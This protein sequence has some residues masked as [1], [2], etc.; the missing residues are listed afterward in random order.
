[1]N[2]LLLG[3]MLASWIVGYRRYGLFSV[4]GALLVGLTAYSIPV[5]LQTYLVPGYWGLSLATV[6]IGAAYVVV[7]AWLWV[8]LGLF[9]FS[10]SSDVVPGQRYWELSPHQAIR[11]RQEISVF[12]VLCA[13]VSTGLYLWIA[14]LDDPLYFLQDRQTADVSAEYQKMLWRWVNVYG[15]ITAVFARFKFLALLFLS[16]IGIYFLA[17]DRTMVLISGVSLLVYFLTE[18][19]SIK[20]VIRLRYILYVMTLGGLLWLGKPIYLAV[21]LQSMLPLERLFSSSTFILE[22][23]FLEPLLTHTILEDVLRSDFSYPWQQLLLGSVGQLLIIPSAFGIDSSA[24]NVSI[25]QNLYPN[26]QY[27]MAAHYFAQGWSVAGPLG[28]A[29]FALLLTYTICFLHRKIKSSWGLRRL[30]FVVVGVT[31]GSYFY[32][33]SLENVLSLI[34]QQL[35]V[36]AALMIVTQA[37]RKY[38][39][40]PAAQGEGSSRLPA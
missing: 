40:R 28:V 6:S 39:Y 38:F 26:I 27:G 12:C 34:R 2:F 8:L 14:L 31:V 29:L 7:W 1:M 4:V 32:R 18:V 35:L 24:F 17:G 30:V 5:V 21:K 9:L 10:T 13:V 19:R 16:Y 20:Q 22:L 11:A 3:L 15:L 36:V 23:S 25:H 37:C 33:N